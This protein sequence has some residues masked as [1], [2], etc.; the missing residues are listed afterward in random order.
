MMNAKEFIQNIVNIRYSLILAFA[1][2]FVLCFY[3]AMADDAKTPTA[4]I[5]QSPYGE[6]MKWVNA[7]LLA[8]IGWF[9]RE[10]VI[11]AKNL[12]TTVNGLTSAVKVHDVKI[13]N[14][15]KSVTSINTKLGVHEE[16]FFEIENRK[17]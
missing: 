17:N 2:T 13:E 4:A 3:L 9:L 8:I 12:I 14:I 6:Y 11:A 5:A 1:F 16:R 7:V 10:A 15:D